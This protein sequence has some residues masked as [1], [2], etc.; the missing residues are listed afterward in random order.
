MPGALALVL[1]ALLALG[2]IAG[3]GGDDDEGSDGS[4]DPQEILDGALGGGGEDID[5]GVLELSFSLQS[6]GQATGE[7]SASLEGP[8]QSGGDGALPMLDFTAVAN[9]DAP[10]Q[11]VD[12]DGGLTLTADGAFVGYRGQDY[13]IDDATFTLLQESYMQ[14]SEL[15]ASQSQEGSLA[16]FGIDPT[17]WV[18]ELTNEGTEDIDG[19]E[20]VHVSGAANVT[21]IV[22]DLSSVAQQT[23][24]S[25]QVD[26]AA[27]SQA[28]SSVEGATLDVYANAADNTLRKLDLSLS[29]ADPS[30]S[31]ETIDV[32]ASI[33]IRD[34]NAEQ[35]ISAPA[36]PQPIADLAAQFPGNDLLGSIGAA[37]GAASTGSGA[38][39]QGSAGS[40]AQGSGGAGAT[41]PGAGAG[42]EYFDCVGKATSPAAVEACSDLLGG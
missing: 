1:A 23:G 16:Q 4:T 28:A 10:G 34:A 26:A 35:E 38:G 21:Q 8:F 5:S 27:L 29:L 40:G 13:Q 17:T 2:L 9:V 39:T 31:S 33:G 24:Q 19:T 37:G 14:S 41:A 22:E 3:C 20:V 42:A 7:V 11:Q 25:G 18:S 12:F 30:G 36:D 32:I 15:Q 6:E